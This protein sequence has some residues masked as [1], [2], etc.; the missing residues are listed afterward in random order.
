[1]QTVSHI[2]LIGGGDASRRRSAGSE[3]GEGGEG[4]TKEA[5]QQA[6]RIVAATLQR[7]GTPFVSVLRCPFD[8][9]AAIAEQ[10]CSAEL[11]D[12]GQVRWS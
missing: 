3:G 5:E 1:M 12:G 2:V 10:Q 11:L 9:L 7:W 6:L 4:L 8:T